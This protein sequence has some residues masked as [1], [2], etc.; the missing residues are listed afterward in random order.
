MRVKAE[1]P[2]C[3]TLSGTFTVVAG[4]QLENALSSIKVT[5]LGIVID[6]NSQPNA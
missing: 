6:D 2:T 1:M 4:E 5:V 3:V